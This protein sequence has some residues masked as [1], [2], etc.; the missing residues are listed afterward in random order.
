MAG[1]EGQR[2]RPLTEDVPK[3]M[4]EVDGKPMLEGV[5]RNVIRSGVTKVYM[6]VNYKREVIEAHFGDGSGFG[7]EIE[8]VHEEQPLGTAGALSL[9][10]ADIDGPFLVING[11]VLTESHFTSLFEYHAKH[12]SVA[13]VAAVEYR[14]QVPLGVLSLTEHHVLG[15]EEKPEVRMLC[16]A[17]I[18]VLNPEVLR[19]VPRDRMFHMTDLI[20]ELVREGLP[21]SA[22][23]LFEQW[24]SIER[25]A[26]LDAINQSRQTQSNLN[27]DERTN[28]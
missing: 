16:S 8:Y 27:P 24:A 17:G 18:Y 1:G 22:Y 21:V 28:A 3:P 10:P 25:P 15:V 7:V 20:N 19:F 14:V 12:H 4:V 23:P 5:L 13:T 6:A 2:M 26:D 9:L 11:D